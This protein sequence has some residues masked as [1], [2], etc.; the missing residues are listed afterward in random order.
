M[1]HVSLARA[2]LLFGLG[3]LLLSARPAAAHRL[4]PIFTEYAQ[5]FAPW[6][7]SLMV[8]GGHRQSG[9]NHEDELGLEMELGVLPRLQISFGQSYV[10][11][12]GDGPR[13]RSGFDNLETGLRYLV[14][15]GKGHGYAV[16]LN[17][18]YTFL[19]G[20]RTV[21]EPSPGYGAAVHADYYA[22]PGFLFFSNVGW[23]QAANREAGQSRDRTVFYH[24]AAVY[25]MSYRWNPTLE[26]IGEQDLTTGQHTVTIVPEI[27][28]YKSQWVELKLGVPIQVNHGGGVGVQLK[29]SFALGRGSHE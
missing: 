28:Y 23:E 21:R 16:S 25:Q 15:G 29:A 17:P 8:E 27:Q 20:S 10:W 5:P 1:R 19:S 24:L 11:E 12:N 22:F 13:Q 4:E 7:G 9:S 2:P 6:T 18:E 3:C 26:L 14:V